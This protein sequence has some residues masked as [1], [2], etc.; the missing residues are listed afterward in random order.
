MEIRI[1]GPLEVVGEGRPLSPG[2]PRQ[3]ALLAI[4][5]LHANELVSRDRLIDEIWGDEPPETAR[6]ALQVYVSQLRK[7]LGRDTIQTRPGGYVLDVAPGELDYRLFEQL[8]RETRGASPAV[9][10][11]QL[12]EALALWR[13][14]PLADLD[15]FVAR[16]E[17]ARLEE[18]R[19]SA[20]EQRIGAD[21]DLGREAELCSRAGGPRPRASV[22]RAAARAAR[23]L[24]C[25]AGTPGR[26]AR[27]L[28]D[29][30]GGC[31]TRSWASSQGRSCGCSRRGSSPRI[32]GSQLR[33]RPFRSDCSRLAGRR[34]R[35]L[36]LVGAVLLVCAV[37][38]AIVRVTTGQG[39]SAVT[40]LP[41]S[42]AVVDTNVRVVADIPVG[43]GPVA[44]AT[45]RGAV[46]VANGDDGTVSRM[47]VEE[48]KVVATIGDRRRGQ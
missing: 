9:A 44:V 43:S 20:L 22:A 15:G 45:S 13:G 2:G 34:R 17:R 16:P 28:Q 47:D 6:T 39:G 12:R 21:L 1:L 42:V 40:V 27:H 48:R 36:I 24:P 11:E 14:P 10:A 5:A 8:V 19:L 32:R 46:W 38:G 30:A 3:R 29:R 23:C 37:A 31:S 33:L 18:E 35:A 4:L 7:T 26:R 25:T 41:N